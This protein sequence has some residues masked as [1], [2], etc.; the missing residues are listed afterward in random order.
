[1]KTSRPQP[2]SFIRCD[3]PNII[4]ETIKRAEDGHGFIVRLYEAQRRRGPI[5]LTTGF[6]LA[7]AWRC[8]LLEENQAEVAVQDNRVE[9]AVKPYEI[10]TLQL[11]AKIA[12][13]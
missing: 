1:M 2:S 4:I 12:H 3:A 11:M 7:S 6:D 13:Q 10:I 9:L 8:N 5:T